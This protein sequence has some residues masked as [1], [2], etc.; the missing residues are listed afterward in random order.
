MRIHARI[1]LCLCVLACW[2]S[3]P[4]CRTWAQEAKPVQVAK[5]VEM[6]VKSGRRVVGTV[7]PLRT[8]T[9]GSAVEG[10]V[11]H[12]YVN[13]GEAVE[14]GQV[15][16]QLLT[17]TLE[18]E[19]AA[20]EAELSL[21]EY[22]LEELKNGSRPETIAEARA[23]M[24]SAKAGMQNATTRRNRVQSL[25]NTRAASSAELD[26]AKQQFEAA[27]FSLKATE[28]LLERIEAGPRAET[29]SQAEARVELQRQRRNLLQ[30]RLSKYSIRAP[31]DGFVSAEYT[32]VG[33][34]ISRADPVVQVIEL[35]EVEI[36]VPV[37]AEGVV[38]LRPGNAVR[39]EFPELPERLL[40]AS[41]DR[42]V[43]M[44]DT[45]ARTFPVVLRL[46]N[47]LREGYPELLAGM[48]ARV[49][50]PTGN[51][52]KWPVV[53]KDALVLNGEDRSV[54]VVDVTQ[55]A[56]E[57]SGRFGSVRRVPVQLGVAYADGIQ[58]K[59]QL[60]AGELVVVVG[61]ERLQPK[62][63]VRVVE[64]VTTVSQRGT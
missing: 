47:I 11:E 3:T 40:T 45:R 17:N 15:L 55:E 52:Q 9:V 16:A 36:H 21:F 32:E 43:P 60:R 10:R 1:S 5:V 42:I 39:V 27:K 22:Q 38:H 62:A 24:M 4:I 44:A 37:P 13:Q 50:L 61:N 2:A 7:M 63:K 19:L 25:A 18:I 58:V 33:A 56:S 6:E 30:D 48:L 12:V 51:P 41:V 29:I 59:G 28:A 54:F 8:S 31:F 64:P 34:W 20:A 23:N 53:P 26:D 46:K 35:A 14:K 57:A 49:D